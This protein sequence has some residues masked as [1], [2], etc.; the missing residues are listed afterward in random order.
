[1]D[2]DGSG[3]VS[4]S[5]FV[6]NVHMARTQEVKTLLMTMK[7]Q[8]FQELRSIRDEIDTFVGNSVHTAVTHIDTGL[9]QIEKEVGYLKPA[10]HPV[11]PALNSTSIPR[12]ASSGASPSSPG[13]VEQ[14]GKLALG[15]RAV[16]ACGEAINRQSLTGVA[17]MPP[18]TIAQQRAP[19]ERSEEEPSVSMATG[20]A[21]GIA[22]AVLKASKDL[23]DSCKDTERHVAALV[24][25]SAELQRLV[26]WN[27]RDHVELPPPLSVNCGQ[28]SH[29]HPIEKQAVGFED[30]GLPLNTQIPGGTAKGDLCNMT[31]VVEKFIGMN[32]PPPSPSVEWT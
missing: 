31:E 10:L 22:E 29:G 20:V 6:E 23:A 25:Q 27:S 1:M 26:K 2:R 4:Y 8:I 16:D 12:R 17:I 19:K 9:H 14:V 21:T 15:L 30:R 18:S 24:Q 32:E 7:Y 3:A 13:S 28:F 11:T 5:E